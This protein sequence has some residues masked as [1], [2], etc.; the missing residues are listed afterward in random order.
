[1]ID[2]LLQ[3]LVDRLDQRYYGKYRGYVHRTDDPL[4]LGRIQAIVP[5]LLEDT[6]TG[7]ALPCAPYAGPDQGLF[8]VP[9]LGAGVWIEFEGGDLTRPIW[10][11]MWWGAPSEADASAADSSAR[12]GGPA[13]EVPQHDRP[14]VTAEPGVRVLKSATGHIITLDDRPG[15]ERLEIED[16]TGNRI[17]LDKEGMIEIV[18]NHKTMNDGNR[19]ARVKGDDSQEVGGSQKETIGGTANRTVNRSATITVGGD[20][21]ESLRNGAYVRTVDANGTSITTGPV[22]ET[23]NGSATRTAAGAIRETTG[24]GFGV[25]SGGGINMAS[26]GGF[27]AAAAFPDLPSLNVISLDGLIG[28][29]SINTKLG[30]MQLGGMSAI[31][32]AVLGDGLLIHLTLLAQI[33]KAVN[34]LTVAAYG[35]ALDAWAAATPALDLSYFAYLKRFPVG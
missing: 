10:A 30:V 34:P 2:D 15:R 24:S 33:L 27:S 28:N 29:I 3:Q 1:M 32:P 4:Q 13:T 8:T 23:V 5:R 6:P 11:G 19:A 26:V 18:H 20:Y 25:V 21:R 7:W 16:S 14:R 31:S 9:E 35:P 22:A 12:Q 17:I